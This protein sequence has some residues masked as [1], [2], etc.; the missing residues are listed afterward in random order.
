M[1][2]RLDLVCHDGNYLAPPGSVNTGAGQPYKIY[3][4]FW[5]A[6]LEQMPPPE[7]LAGRRKHSE[8]LTRGRRAIGWRIGSCCPN[9]PTGLADSAEWTPG[10]A[11]AQERLD[12][13]VPKAEL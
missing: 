2:K 9:N 7:P 1:C 5:R 11:G 6:L 8:R 10:E 4:P 13:F 3:T 12:D